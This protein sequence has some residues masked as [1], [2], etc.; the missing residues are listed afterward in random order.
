[1]CEMLGTE[2]VLDEGQPQRWA[3]I[4]FP[5]SPLWLVIIPMLPDCQKRQ[6]A[7]FS[8]HLMS[9]QM[10]AANI[11]CPLHICITNGKRAVYGAVSVTL[12]LSP[13]SRA[14]LHYWAN[15]PQGIGLNY[16]SFNHIMDLGG[17]TGRPTFI[18]FCFFN[19]NREMIGR[20]WEG[21]LFI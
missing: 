21:R 6:R 20:H 3:F 7:K 1:M 18:T 5:E 17:P 15:F 11:C 4:M 10:F 12:A 9:I 14:L 19:H 13:L 2:Q 16:C 8:W